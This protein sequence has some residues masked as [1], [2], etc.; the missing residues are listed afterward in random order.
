[1]KPLYCEPGF[2]S[3]SKSIKIWYP[4]SKYLEDIFLWQ[5][6]SYSRGIYLSSAADT[7]FGCLKPTT[8]GPRTSGNG[9]ESGG[10]VTSG[11]NQTEGDP[12]SSNNTQ[13]FSKKVPVQ[14]LLILSQIILISICLL[15]VCRSLS[16]LRDIWD[17]E[18][19][20]VKR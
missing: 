2:N 9:R 3:K 10:T 20:N 16:K 6:K 14:S 18:G 19:L 11:M 8:M 1:M 12:P 15:I 5:K 4:L 7:T 17:R 13:T